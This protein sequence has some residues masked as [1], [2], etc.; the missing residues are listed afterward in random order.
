MGTP[1][2]TKTNKELAAK[3]AAH[4]KSINIKETNMGIKNALFSNPKTTLAGIFSALGYVLPLFG[5]PISPEISQAMQVIGVALIG[6]L[7]HDSAPTTATAE[8]ATGK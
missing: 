8:S 3:Y 2:S 7:A 4:A 6:L 5:I 1:I